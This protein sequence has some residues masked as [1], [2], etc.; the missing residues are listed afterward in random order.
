NRLTAAVGAL[1]KHDEGMIRISR[2]MDLRVSDLQNT[3]MRLRMQPCKRLFQQL[4]RV[5]RDLSRQTHKDVRLEIVGEALEIAK[6]WAEA[7]PARLP[8]LV[9]NGLAH[10]TEPPEVRNSAQK[11]PTALLRIAAVHLGDKVRIEVSDDGQGIDRQVVTQKA[12]Q[13][14]VITVDEA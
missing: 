3:V 6:P 13:K 1:S 12:I 8:P 7:P 10:G 11:P 14:G 2:E 9:R 5:V 4:P